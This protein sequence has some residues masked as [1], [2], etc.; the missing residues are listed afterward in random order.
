MSVEEPDQS[1][2]RMARAIKEAI[3]ERTAIETELAQLR[4]C[5]VPLLSELPAVDSSA[6]HLRASAVPRADLTNVETLLEKR[7]ALEE[8]LIWL[9]QQLSGM[10]P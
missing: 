4:D 1:Y 3:R 5:L 8:R 2:G 6:F 9:N 7:E 10:Q